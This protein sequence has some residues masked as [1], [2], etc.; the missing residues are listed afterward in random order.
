MP[1]TTVVNAYRELAAE[2]LVVGHVGRGTIVVGA[3]GDGADGGHARGIPWSQLF[4]G[5]TEVMNDPLLRDTML[6]SARSDVI[7]L[8]TGIPSPDLYPIETIRALLDEAL[9]AAGQELLQH[10]PTE[11]YPPLRAALAEWTAGE[12]QPVAPDQV[13]IVAG[14]QQ[15]LYL[16]ARALLE[17]GD[18]VAVE[19]P[20]YLGALQVFRAAGA[21]LLPIPVDEHGMRVGLLEDLIGRRRPKLIYTL[22]TFQNPTGA[23]MSLERRQRLLAL[24][25]RYQVPVVEDDPYGALRYDG[26]PIPPLHALDTHGTVIYLS[27]L[28]KIL[29]PGFRIGWIA[30]PRPVIERLALMKQIVDLDT[31]PLA[32]WAVWAFLDRGLLG[33]H[34]ARLRQIYPRRRD[35][36]LAAIERHCAGMLTCERPAGGLYVWGWLAD[37]LRARDLLP[38]AARRGVAIAPGSSFHPDGTGESTLRL[39]FT[40]PREEEIDVAIARLG[41]AIAAL[42]A[43][44]TGG[45]E[46]R[47]A[48]RATPIV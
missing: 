27:T 15:G 33:Q 17:P 14:S 12:G 45:P 48:A 46:R 2:G 10:C 37:G 21:R 19:S 36:M 40:L 26:R 6:V 11:G 47:E 30:A 18:L 35:R 43:S 39:N 23:T 22:P 28:S 42:R 41:E 8:A 13:L 32:Q 16:L 25:A 34:V 31:N 38:E 29:F 7:S 4:T 9:H 24:A 3:T 5:V 20:T 44:R 1:C